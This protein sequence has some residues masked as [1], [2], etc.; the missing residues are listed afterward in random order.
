M[1]RVQ[2]STTMMTHNH[3]N[4]SNTISSPRRGYSP[5]WQGIFMVPN[6]MGDSTDCSDSCLFLPLGNVLMEPLGIP[7]TWYGTMQGETTD[8]I[9]SRRI[10][11][12]GWHGKRQFGLCLWCQM[13]IEQTVMTAFALSQANSSMHHNYR[14]AWRKRFGVQVMY[15]MKL[16]HKCPCFCSSDI[17]MLTQVLSRTEAS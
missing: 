4:V 12:V 3:T 11:R 6:E 16:R 8:I 10:G 5:E 13:R 2:D 15:I 9:L 1:W 7:K 17:M 14:M